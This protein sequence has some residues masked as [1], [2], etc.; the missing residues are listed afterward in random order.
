[1]GVD[2]LNQAASALQDP[3]ADDATVCSATKAF[4]SGV[5]QLQEPHRATFLRYMANP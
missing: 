3:T 4:I 5:L 1:M 2:Q